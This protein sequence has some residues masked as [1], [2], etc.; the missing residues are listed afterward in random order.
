MW[1]TNQTRPDIFNAIQAVAR[2]SHSPELV[3]WKAA[4]HIPQYIR[5]TSGHGILFQRGMDSG[6]D[7]EL[8]VDS[9]FASRDTNRLCLGVS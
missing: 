2:Y 4:L 7:L 3:H 9:D 8:Y 6:V 1:L 5:F